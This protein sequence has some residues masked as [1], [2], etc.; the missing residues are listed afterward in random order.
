VAGGRVDKGEHFSPNCQ[1]D[2]RAESW[3]LLW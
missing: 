1:E 3:S 2:L